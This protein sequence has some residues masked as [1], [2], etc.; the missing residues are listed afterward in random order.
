MTVA[1]RRVIQPVR[2]YSLLAFRQPRWQEY[3]QYLQEA[4]AAGYE[5]VPL[6]SWLTAGDTAGPTVV[7]RH[8]V[9]L[10]PAN[11]RVM[12]D[13]EQELGVSSTYYFRWTTFDLPVIRALLA[14]GHRIGLHY[15]TL[16]RVA[17]ERGLYRPEQITPS[18][19]AVCRAEL[20][21]EIAEFQRRTGTGATIC[22]HGDRRARTI[23]VR[24]AELLIGE[25]YE[26]YGI[27]AS[28][29]DLDAHA[30]IDCWVTDGEDVDTTWGSGI[31]ISGSVSKGFGTILFN[32]HPNH[33]GHGR[34]VVANR[35]GSHAAW[36][37]RHPRLH[38]EW[39]EPECLAWNRFRP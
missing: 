34:L 24:N 22:A 37:A 8:D 13:I 7:M 19:M 35:L 28:A 2:K 33:W 11:A 10:L 15:E 4:R 17:R 26:D 31:S 5:L 3:A 20:K 38:P 39:G 18:V 6:E 25:R 27:T 32:S 36:Y 29:D 21:E 14:A 12:G 1:V 23:G 30:R 9:D 16:T